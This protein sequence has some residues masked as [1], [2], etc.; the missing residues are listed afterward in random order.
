MHPFATLGPGA[1][2]LTVAAGD[3]AAGD[4]AAGDAAGGEAAGGDAAGGA[5]LSIAEQSVGLLTQGDASQPPESN[6]YDENG[7]P[8]A[9]A[10]TFAAGAVITAVVRTASAAQTVAVYN[11]LLTQKDDVYPLDPTLASADD[12]G[13]PAHSLHGEWDASGT[14]LA[15]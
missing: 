2:A 11:T 15:R 12:V 3:A 8:I 5:G 13:D 14:Q 4:A 1:V 9:S 7:N 6:G 10:T